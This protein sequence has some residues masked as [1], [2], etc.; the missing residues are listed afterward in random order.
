MSEDDNQVPTALVAVGTKA[1]AVRSA[2]LVTRGLA[3]AKSLP[4]P[5]LQ[6]SAQRFVSRFNQI[7][8][9][10]QG[11]AAVHYNLGVELKDKGDLDGA[12]AEYRT[13]IRLDPDF[14]SAHYNLGVAL[15]HK[16]DLDGTIAEYRTAIR[17][18]PDD[19]YA[20]NNLG[21]TLE[22]KGD[23]DGGIREYREALHLKPDDAIAHNNL[24]NALMQKGDLLAALDEVEKA[25][26]LDPKNPS[27][28]E[29]T[30]RIRRKAKG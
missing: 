23:L 16:G 12:I 6:S 29:V 27:I 9:S 17:L 25:R 28:A 26:K 11:D 8:V 24:A 10:R 3:L 2:T 20:H 13:A 18:Y 19:A 7:A 22:E 4:A 15:T 5:K 21:A 1:L 14:A 30:E